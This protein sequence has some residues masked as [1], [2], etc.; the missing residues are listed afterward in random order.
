MSDY[1]ADIF[2]AISC[3]TPTKGSELYID[4]FGDLWMLIPKLNRFGEQSVF[5]QY[6]GNLALM[7]DRGQMYQGQLYVCELIPGYHLV[8]TNQAVMVN[9]YSL[10]QYVKTRAAKVEARYRKKPKP[11][12]RAYA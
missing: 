10:V 6:A 12:S 3:K 4:D 5:R 8:L 2:K 1:C 7:A 11:M 9:Q